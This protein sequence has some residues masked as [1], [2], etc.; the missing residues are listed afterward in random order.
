MQMN[1]ELLNVELF[2]CKKKM[3]QLKTTAPTDRRVHLQRRLKVH[4]DA[5]NEKAVKDVVQITRKETKEKR[6]WRLR[7]T[8]KPDQGGAVY[9]V[10]RVQQD[11]NTVGGGQHGRWDF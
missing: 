3:E 4:R 2:L 5:G 7:W 8:T 11:G 10:P 1:V 9:N 6:F